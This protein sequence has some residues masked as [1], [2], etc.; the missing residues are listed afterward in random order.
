MMCE[1]RDTVDHRERVSEVSCVFYDEG[2]FTVK[3][4]DVPKEKELKIKVNGT[5]IVNVLCTPLKLDF[6][7]Y[8]YLYLE[9]FISKTGDVKELKWSEC[10]DEVELTIPKDSSLKLEG[11]TIPVGLGGGLVYKGKRKIKS[12]LKISP[13]DLIQLIEGFN[14]YCELERNAEGIHT[15]AISDLKD[16]V[17]IADDI[18]R[19][20]TIDKIAGESLLREFETK[21]KILLTT[22]R[23]SSDMVF[24][25]AKMGVPILVTRRSPTEGAIYHAKDLGITLVGQAQK[26]RFSVFSHAERVGFFGKLGGKNG[27]KD[28]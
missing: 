2:A 21:D 20:N 17:I 22:G 6:L 7:V 3:K 13:Q 14:R 19:H 27:R 16:L 26:S 11:K 10:K 23:I 8:G 15:S 1:S 18:G 24:K 5:E 4:K 12:G 25:A 28:T 9:G